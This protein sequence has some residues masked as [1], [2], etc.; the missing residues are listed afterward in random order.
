MDR[1]TPKRIWTSVW[2][3]VGPLALFACL[4]AA[5]AAAVPVFS[6]LVPEVHSGTIRGSQTWSGLHRIS[7]DLVVRGGQ[8]R[9][10]CG[11]HVE[12]APGTTVELVDGGRVVSDGRPGCPVVWTSSSRKPTSGDWNGLVV[13]AGGELDAR[14]TEIA[15]AGGGGAAVRVLEGGRASLERTVVHSAPGGGLEVRPGGELASAE[16][17]QFWE[18]QGDPVRVPADQLDVVEA[19]VLEETARTIVVLGGTVGRPATWEFPGM[20][21]QVVGD[22]H[23]RAPTEVAAET[24]MYL[25]ADSTVSVESGG[26]IRAVGGDDLGYGERRQWVRL[27]FGPESRLTIRRSSGPENLFRWV[28]VGGA[29][30]FEVDEGADVEFENARFVD[31]EYA[32][33]VDLAASHR[34]PQSFHTAS[35]GFR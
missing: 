8:V 32:G 33:V 4:V 10:R 21:L 15:Y 9:V 7:D 1:W 18:L 17:L 31:S 25:F 5:V 26:A 29:G 14:K 12:M 24:S 23:V 22:V 34:A 2:E 30:T 27:N 13:R 19:P 20:T 28:V 35:R 3:I 6:A 16:G 11:T